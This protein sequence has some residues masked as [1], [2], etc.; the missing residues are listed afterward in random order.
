MDNMGNE[1]GGRN[2]YAMFYLF[3][4]LFFGWILT[5]FILINQNS[6]IISENQ[7]TGA[8]LQIDPISGLGTFF[9]NEINVAGNSLPLW[10]LLLAFALIFSVIF[11]AAQLISFFKGDEKR[12]AVIVFSLAISLLATFTTPLVAWVVVLA[13]YIGSLATIIALLLLGLVFYFFSHKA[14]SERFTDIT[15]SA[16]KRQQARNVLLESRYNEPQPPSRTIQQQAQQQRQVRQ[17]QQNLRQQQQVRAKWAIF[18]QQAQQNLSLLANQLSNQRNWNTVIGQ[19]ARISQIRTD[20]PKIRTGN[21][22][23]LLRTGQTH[24]QR[25]LANPNDT[26]TIALATQFLSNLQTTYNLILNQL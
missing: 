25:I 22:G 16:A 23:A 8:A 5:Q 7:V 19:L 24:M 6:L 4:I 21:I 1:I 18:L 3:L 2:D 17:A 26:R 11:N 15:E 10:A 13:A 12:G 9:S 20:L 14:I